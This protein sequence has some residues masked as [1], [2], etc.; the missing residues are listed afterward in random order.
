M[1]R[2]AT[3]VDIAEAAGVS[4]ATVDRVLNHR[5][6]VRHETALRVVEAAERIGY[7]AAGLLK[8][9]MKEAPGRRL[10]FL[11]QKPD[12][13]YRALARRWLPKRRPRRTQPAGR[14][15]SSTRKSARQ[16][17]RSGY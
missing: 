16:R 4:I 15:S 3:I 7:H 5:L 1:A 6:P 13:F 12:E 9:R 14:S 17:S 8:Q 10:G 11:L 2:R